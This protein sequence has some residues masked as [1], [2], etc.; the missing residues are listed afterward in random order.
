VLLGNI[1]LYRHDAHLDVTVSGRF[2]PPPELET[3]AHSLQRDVILTYL[4]Q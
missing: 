2:S 1:A 3:I 4:L